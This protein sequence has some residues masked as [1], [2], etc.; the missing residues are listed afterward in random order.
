MRPESKDVVDLPQPNPGT[1]GDGREKLRLKPNQLE[2]EVGGQREMRL[3][4][5]DSPLKESEGIIKRDI[6][7]KEVNNLAHPGRRR[8]TPDTEDEDLR[9]AENSGRQELMTLDLQ[10]TVKGGSK[11]F[12]G[13]TG[14]GDMGGGGVIEQVVGLFQEGGMI[15]DHQ[16]A[17][18]RR[19]NGHILPAQVDVS[20]Q[21]EV[22][23]SPQEEVDVS[24]QEEVSVSPKGEVDVSPQG[25]VDVSP[26]GEVDASPQGEVDVSPQG[27][28]DVSPQGEVDDPIYLHGLS[29][30]TCGTLY[31]CI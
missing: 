30:L 6:G 12:S 5:K 8:D 16:V 13:V 28:V 14:Q 23:V 21:G 15:E 18:A 9:A 10:A 27:E 22:D 25:E 2:E 1:K 29:C 7:G 20:P 3:L 17:L 11:A 26:Q 31:T 24:P 19:Q 4:G